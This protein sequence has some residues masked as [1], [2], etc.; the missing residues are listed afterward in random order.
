MDET[1]QSDQREERPASAKR[2]EK[3]SCFVLA[4][5]GLPFDRYYSN[6]FVPAVQDAGL[7]PIR[8]DSLFRPSPIMD[9]IWRFVRGATVLIADLTTKNPNVFYEL[10][11]A[12]AIAKPV[13]L[14]ANTIDDVPFDLRGL[15]VLTYGPNGLLK[16]RSKQSFG[17]S[18]KRSLPCGPS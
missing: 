5:F 14:V 8:A 1:S 13:I 18:P 7:L 15:R 16:A 9:D 6:I 10:G 11:L 4:P 12:H 3:P 2:V 17:G